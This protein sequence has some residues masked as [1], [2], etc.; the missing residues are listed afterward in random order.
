MDGEPLNNELY[1]TLLESLLAA[2]KAA[3]PCLRLY[4]TSGD[5]HFIYIADDKG[6]T[7]DLVI[8]SN[9]SIRVYRYGDSITTYDFELS[10]PNLWDDIVQVVGRELS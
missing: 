10:N 4:V 7:S 3:H 8:Y 9:F 5:T 2:I 1:A 6:A